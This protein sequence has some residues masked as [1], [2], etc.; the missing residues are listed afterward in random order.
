VDNIGF[1][2]GLGFIPRHLTVTM[3]RDDV[4]R[5]SGM[6]LVRLSELERGARNAT[7][8]RCRESV[9]RVFAGY[10]YTR[11]FDLSLDLGIGDV[12]VLRDANDVVGFAL[13]HSAPLAHN[14][15]AD[16]LRVLKLFAHSLDA[17]R[18]VVLALESCATTLG[19]TSLAIRCQTAYQDAYLALI[20][21]GY[22][23][24]ATKNRASLAA[25]S[26]SQTGK[27]D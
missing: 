27:S 4:G 13:W 16:E 6:P 26:Y 17:F 2:G 20:D 10:D 1:Y 14:R 22:R 11:E 23:V 19:L 24:L 18:Q 15:L 7:T 25:R 5:E 12:V 8:G 9:E 3:T 21:M